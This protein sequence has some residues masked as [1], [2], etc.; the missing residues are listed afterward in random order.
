M[1]SRNA[2][3]LIIVSAGLLLFI[4]AQWPRL[5]IPA[6]LVMLVVMGFALRSMRRTPPDLEP[7]SPTRRNTIRRAAGIAIALALLLWA[8][9][10][11]RHG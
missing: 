2:Q 4:A 5:T 6:C 8:L 7:P 11:L 9:L 3:L 10:S 1:R